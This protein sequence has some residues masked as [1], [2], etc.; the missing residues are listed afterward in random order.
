[1]GRRELL[2]IMP[3]LRALQENLIQYE[4]AAAMERQKRDVLIATWR[5]L[6]HES[7]K[8]P[9]AVHMINLVHQV[10]NNMD[11]FLRRSKQ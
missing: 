1:M 11:E 8:S 4:I 7:M 2:G 3:E 9:G 10:M 5:D 6:L